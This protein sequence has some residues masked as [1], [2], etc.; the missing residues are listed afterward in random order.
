MADP[1]RIQKLTDAADV[2]RFGVLYHV[3][4]RVVF[5]MET[6][7]P[8]DVLTL[9]LVATHPAVRLAAVTV[10]PGTP[11][12]LGVVRTVLDRLGVQ[13]PVG[14]RVAAGHGGP[15]AVS[16]FHHHW[17]GDTLPAQPDGVAH[18]MLARVLTDDPDTVLLTGAPLHNLRLLLNNHGDVTVRR[19]V[20]QGG[21]AGD[22][23]VAAG[24]LL[25][26][27]AGSV[28]QASYNFGHD[29]K[30]ALLAL[31]SERIGERRLVS[32]N[33]THGVVW[34]HHLH[35]RIAARPD[36]TVGVRLAVE[37]MAVY[38][39]QRPEGKL[40]HD[41]LAAAAVVD[42][43][44]F[45]WVEVEVFREQGLWGARPLAGTHTFITV[46]VDG[47]RALAALLGDVCK[48]AASDRLRS[49]GPY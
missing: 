45:R 38:L 12:Q 19:W 29:A 32:K 41:P 20:A 49:A 11:A 9:C 8:D 13:V 43:A 37:A 31:S 27:F 17:L 14:A 28:T 46:G 24:D 18:E 44:A 6:R 15:D 34:D 36:L 23:I 30:A 48:T 25:D 26:K 2:C 33:V 1:A 40:L 3:G 35:R 39:E 47:E 5:D 21:F 7:D 22:N 16:P 10:N 4:M 42:P